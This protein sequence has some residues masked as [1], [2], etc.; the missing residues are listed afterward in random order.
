MGQA[1]PLHRFKARPRFQP[2]LPSE[3]GE[4][5]ALLL[6]GLRGNP[7]PLATRRAGFESTA[8]GNLKPRAVL[9]S[10]WESS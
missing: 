2:D 6:L 3:L 4:T 1:G 8:F 7:S 9:G 10:D 5:G